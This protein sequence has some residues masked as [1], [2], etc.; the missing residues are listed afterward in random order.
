MIISRW[1]AYHCFSE[2]SEELPSYVS[3]VD[4]MCDIGA[5]VSVGNSADSADEYHVLSSMGK[6]AACYS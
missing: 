1:Y 5:A 4:T 6:A 2:E 3:V